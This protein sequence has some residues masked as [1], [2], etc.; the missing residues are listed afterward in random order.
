ME[1]DIT[2]EDRIKVAARKLFQQKG[3]AATR[4]RDIAE[5]AGINLAMLN[6]YYRSKERL[7]Q[8]IME[9]GISKIFFSIQKVLNDDTTTL[10]QKMEE[11]VSA[12]IDSLSENPNLPL[13]IL[14]E[15]QANP[16]NITKR[17]GLS[18]EFIMQSVVYKQLKAH[19]KEKGLEDLNP[20]HIPINVLSMTIFPF[21]AKPILTSVS[22][23]DEKAFCRFA[24]ERK[25]LIPL[26]VKSMLKMD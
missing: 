2:T 11:M 21:I 16:E 4:T 15:I 8:Q 1:K 14:G 25:K 17:I 26:W 13:F 10:Y 20:L 18:E 22:G 12:Y 24:E 7:F 3:Y 6:Y 9:E 5:E 19:I 23:M